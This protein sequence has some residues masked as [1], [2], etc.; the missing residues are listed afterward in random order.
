MIGKFAINSIQGEPFQLRV[1]PEGEHCRIQFIQP[2]RHLVSPEFSIDLEVSKS[3]TVELRS[4]DIPITGMT[5]E[6][7]APTLLPG[8][9]QIRIGQQLFD[10]MQA[11]IV[12]DGTTYEWQDQL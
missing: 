2:D 7:H 8:R 9:F 10:V 4:A 6:F 12:V 3:Q 1:I 11:R 5:V